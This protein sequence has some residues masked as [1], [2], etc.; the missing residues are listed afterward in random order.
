MR[1][2]AFATLLA[3]PLALRAQVDT[4]PC[5][6]CVEWNAPQR[7]FRIHGD[8]W[9][10]GTRGLSAILVTS[11]QGHVLLDGGLPES[12]ARIAE[13]VRALGFRMEDVRVILNSH[14][15]YDHAGGLAA[16]Q[17]MSGATVAA[18]PW[19]A[20]VMRRGTTLPEDPQHG[21]DIPYPAVPTVRALADGETVRVGPLALTAHF[22]GGHTPGGTT[23]SW[24][25]CEKERCL[26]LVYADSQTPVSADGFLF[27]R[28]TRYPQALQD[29]ARGHA[30][31]ERLRCDVLLTPHPGFSELFERL[32]AREQGRA[33]A[34]RDPSACR[35]LAADARQRLARRVATKRAATER[36]V[37]PATRPSAP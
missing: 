28:N 27:T 13:N 35:R 21:L 16:L 1:L 29:F 20:A 5:A 2:L 4:T 10:V 6:S 12:A 3:A 34:F 14:A 22:T 33:D 17:R 11:P 8:S 23:W 7:P 9:Y 25:A 18:H 15:H 19:S 32:A 37:P 26:D 24:R 30:T 31:L 36:A